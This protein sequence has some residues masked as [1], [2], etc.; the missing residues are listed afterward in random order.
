MEIDK[1]EQD[2]QFYWRIKDNNHK[3]IGVGGEGFTTKQ[4]ASVSLDNLVQEITQDALGSDEFV[5]FRKEHWEEAIH[6]LQ[7]MVLA[8]ESKQAVQQFLDS[9]KGAQ[10]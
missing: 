6:R 10:L 9:M 3:I 7:M 2:G 4:H 1:S 5:I 8:G